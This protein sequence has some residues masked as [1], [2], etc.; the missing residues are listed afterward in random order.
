LI[1][2]SFLSPPNPYGPRSKKSQEGI[3]PCAAMPTAKEKI[4]AIFREAGYF[5]FVDGFFSNLYPGK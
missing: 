5:L 3:S 2:F 4:S 1:E